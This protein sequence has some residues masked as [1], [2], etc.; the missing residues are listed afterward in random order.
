M[1]LANSSTSQKS[2]RNA[3]EVISATPLVLEMIA[4]T[5]AAIASRAAIPNGSTTDGRT[6]TEATGE[7]EL[8]LLVRH[9]SEEHHPVADSEGGGQ[10]EEARVL[11]PLAGDDEQDVRELGER[12]AQRPGG[13]CRRPSSPRADRR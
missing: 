8:P 1:R 12:P 3:P 7:Q 5:P 10:V 9:V 13:T 2:T 11:G 4:G 6:N